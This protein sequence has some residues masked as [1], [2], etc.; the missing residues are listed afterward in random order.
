[1]PRH[2][3][4]LGQ[5]VVAHG[6]GIPPGPYVIVRLLPPVGEH[7]HYQGKSKDGVIRALLETQIK[8]TASVSAVEKPVGGRTAA[9]E[10]AKSIIGKPGGTP[11]RRGNK[12]ARALKTTAL[13]EPAWP[14]QMPE[15]SPWE[16]DEAPAGL[17]DAMRE[18]LLKYPPR[19]VAP[20]ERRLVGEWLARAGDVCAA[21]V[22]GR[23]SDDPAFLRRIVIA[24]GPGGHT[25]H[26]IYAPAGLRL[27]VK[28]TV[29]R[30]ASYEM[31]D[32]L[33]TALNSIR[34]VFR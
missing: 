15:P 21:Y 6:P 2:R 22:S 29:G 28:I 4:G 24:A 34:R 14:E 3:F 31:F 32:A 25:T 5:S 9:R 17:P 11:H 13:Q 1:M 19:E 30:D 33:P 7:P 8:D 20:G 16:D 26:L 10:G 18:T 12:G 27:W 23:K